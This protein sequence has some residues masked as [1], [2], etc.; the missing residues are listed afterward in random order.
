MTLTRHFA[1]A[2]FV[3]LTFILVPKV[4]NNIALLNLFRGDV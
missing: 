2:Q 3:S 1:I 4:L